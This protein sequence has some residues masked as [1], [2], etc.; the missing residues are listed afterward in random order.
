MRNLKIITL[1][2]AVI[3]NENLYCYIFFFNYF[4][5]LYSIMHK[6]IVIPLGR[7]AT[8]VPCKLLPIAF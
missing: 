3:T 8:N 5:I 4:I 7:L 1:N 6:K 2:F